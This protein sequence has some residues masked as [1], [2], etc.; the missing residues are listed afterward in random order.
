LSHLARSKLDPDDQDG[1]NTIG[2]ALMLALELAIFTPSL[3]G[4]TAVDR[5]AR[6]RK[7]AT[8]EERNA[9]EALKRASF[10]LLR[11]C[12][13]ERNALFSVEDL[14]TEKILSLLDHDLPVTRA[15]QSPAPKA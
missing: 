2:Q 9:L 1:P 15:A 13:H 5:F 14:A 6:Q 4:S 11:I 7:S 10:R 12:S 3:S 8:E